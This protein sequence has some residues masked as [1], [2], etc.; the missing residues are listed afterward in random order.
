[1]NKTMACMILV[2]APALA[3]GC[4]VESLPEAEQI[5]SEVNAVAAPAVEL[6]FANIT[7]THT[8][9]AGGQCPC[10]M[11]GMLSGF[12]E[13][14]NLGYSKDVV[15]HYTTD[16]DPAAWQDVHAS[17]FGPAGGNRE[18]WYF[19]TERSSRPYVLDIDFRFALR[20]TV[21]GNT[22][23]DNNGGWNYCAGAGQGVYGCPGAELGKS[24]LTLTAGRYEIGGGSAPTRLSGE[25]LLQSFAYDKTVKAVYTTDGWSTVNAAVA[26]YAGPANPGEELWQ[27][28]TIV[29]VVPEIQFAIAYEVNGQTLWDNNVGRNYKIAPQ[30]A[31]YLGE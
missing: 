26:T 2:A 8:L 17:Y 10:T 7:E 21:N 4:G 3:G 29:P 23:W 18:L 24:A 11:Y 19:E 12:I 15:V 30:T 6:L 13:V 1:M 14:E 5:A 31:I 16:P 27:F 9:G 20:L 22:T 25:V 28:S